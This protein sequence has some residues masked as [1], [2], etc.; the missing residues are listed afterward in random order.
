MFL[1]HKYT[2]SSWITYLNE[3][4]LET[5]GVDGEDDT[6][7]KPLVSNKA[8]KAADVFS[9]VTALVHQS[10]EWGTEPATGGAPAGEHLI[11]HTVR[12]SFSV[13]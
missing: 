10:V 3:T 1:D 12:D 2:A 6:C 7:E 8:V 9:G 11:T 5:D 4:H 13:P